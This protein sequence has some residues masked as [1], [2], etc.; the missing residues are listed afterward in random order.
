MIDIILAVLCFLLMARNAVAIKE[1]RLAWG[2]GAAMAFNWFLAALILHG[3][4]IA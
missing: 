1:Q 4:A 2:C 3:R